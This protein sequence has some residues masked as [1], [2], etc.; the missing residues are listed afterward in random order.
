[1][2]GGSR[3][4]AAQLSEEA[5]SLKDFMATGVGD[6]AGPGARVRVNGAMKGP[7]LGLNQ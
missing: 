3:T 2:Q 6:L 1:M 4:L 7:G 5:G